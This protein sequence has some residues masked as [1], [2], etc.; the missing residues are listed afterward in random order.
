M[1][2][3]AWAFLVAVSL[4]GSPSP[5]LRDA[6]ADASPGPAA[7][8]QASFDTSLTP[9]VESTF[10]D[11]RGL[12][13]LLDRFGQLDL[14]MQ[15]VRDE[16]STAVQRTLATIPSSSPP[17]LSAS[18]GNASSCPEK[19]RASYGRAA[20]AGARF[21]ELGR[22]LEMLYRQIR[23]AD[24]LEETQALTPD[25]RNQAKVAR[26]AYRAL[27]TDFR[28][29][30]VAFYEQL[31]AELRHAGCDRRMLATALAAS[32]DG[33]DPGDASSW[34]FEGEEAA[35]SPSLPNGGTKPVVGGTPA[36]G[37]VPLVSN[38]PSIWITVDNAG[39]AAEARVVLDGGAPLSVAGGK[40][41]SIRTSAG[42]HDLCALTA[43]DQRSCG[44]AG[45]VRRA[46]L[47]EGWTLTLHCPR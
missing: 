9:R 32:T 39:C 27:L 40:Q 1:A 25:Y 16:F 26:E 12:R 3:V 34:S 31:G 15:K 10:L 13:A 18:P 4:S 7:A 5:G 11:A 37:A 46:Y 33:P 23:R 41:L 2:G 42:P 22:S 44:A 30:H 43:G 8:G 47:H 20:A 38:A 28:E 19:A 24:E 35:P 6:A 14:E 21:L 45:T 17:A 29:M 36:E